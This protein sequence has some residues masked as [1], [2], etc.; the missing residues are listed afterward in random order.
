ML[1][2]QSDLV[3]QMFFYRIGHFWLTCDYFCFFLTDKRWRLRN[4][5]SNAEATYFR[6][7]PG[8][9]NQ[10]ILAENC[11]A[12]SVA[13]LG[14]SAK[15]KRFSN[16]AVRELH[17]KATDLPLICKG[18]SLNI[19]TSKR[20]KSDAFGSFIWPQFLLAEVPIKSLSVPGVEK[21]LHD[22]IGNFLTW[23]AEKIGVQSFERYFVCIEWDCRR[24][25]Y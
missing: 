2:F 1:F 21:Y 23:L 16:F 22:V 7:C 6:P 15:K 5:H 14:I 9:Q 24:N 4:K 10:Q 17:Q 12:E 20:V 25:S 18:N 8:S 11:R 3:K 19:G 13:S